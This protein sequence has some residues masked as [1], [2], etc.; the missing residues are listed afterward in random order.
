MTNA[1][2]V[3]F[4]VQA[5]EHVGVEI[6]SALL[7]QAG[8]SVEIFF[9]PRIWRDGYSYN[10]HL[11]RAFNMEE[12]IVQEIL[13]SDVDIMA[14]SVVTDNYATA[15]RM[16]GRLKQEKNIPTVFGG[17]HCTSV[18]ERVAAMAEVDY[19]VIGEGEYPLVEL[20]EALSNGTSPHTIQN[21]WYKAPDGL[22][23]S[24]SARP[25]ISN[26]D[27][28]PFIEKDE[29]YAKA[30]HFFKKRYI[31]TAS[32]GCVYA[33]TF[34]NNSMYKQMYNRS[35]KGKWYRRR[36]V[37]NLMDE[38]VSAHEKYNYEYVFFWDEI[39]IDNH[40]WL[41]EF[42]AEYGKRLGI[43]FWCYGYARYVNQ[44]VV[45]VMEEAGCREMNIGVQTIRKET[46]K[47]IKRGD[48]NEKIAEAIKIIGKSKINLCTGNILQLPG[49]SVEEAKELVEFYSDYRVDLPITGFLR[50]YPRTEIVDTGLKMGVLTEQDVEVIERA[51][52][53]NPF[54]V[55]NTEDNWEFKKLQILIQMTPWSPRFLVR[56]VLHSGLYRMLP[57]GTFAALVVTRF[58]NLRSILLGKRHA[59]ESYTGIQYLRVMAKYGWEKLVWKM[60]SRA[61]GPPPVKAIPIPNPRSLR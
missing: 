40:E 38:L 42:C 39:F 15:I 19:V 3:G 51:E 31:T 21:L 4:Y 56:Y 61:P 58:S 28:L 5:T 22:L 45:D 8:H 26:L 27:T 49:Q 30:P 46:R 53:E 18:P 55:P 57:T 48:R 20:V 36:S 7:K 17:I 47:I 2:K 44:H 25:V 11:A 33:C 6:L 16:A 34:C 14:F 29:F 50:Y 1:M 13:T 10:K 54:T 59:Q 37:K 32:R 9:D 52:V 41:E 35:G 24:N 43:P 60:K 12:V 23:I